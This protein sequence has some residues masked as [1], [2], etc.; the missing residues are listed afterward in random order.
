MPLSAEELAALGIKGHY[1]Y[2][3]YNQLIASDP[4]YLAAVGP[5][6]TISNQEKGATDLRKNTIRS[7]ITAFG[8]PSL[9]PGGAQGQFGSFLGT[10]PDLS[11]DVDA[12]ALAAAHGNQYSTLA[13][14]ALNDLR[15]N[16][17]I[18][19]S[20]AGRGTLYS[21][22]YAGGLRREQEAYGRQTYTDVMDLLTKMGTAGS[23]WLDTWNA[24]QGDRL[25]ALTSAGE[26]V[27]GLYPGTWVPDPEGGDGGAG[28]GGGGGGG[29][30]GPGPT[31]GGG[32]VTPGQVP[33]NPN[34]YGGVLAPPDDYSGVNTTPLI[35]PPQYNAPPANAYIPPVPTPNITGANPYHYG[36]VLNPDWF[37]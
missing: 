10:H 8:D 35:A 32:A 31:V 29:G 7:L 30:A 23:S 16:T 12:S 13:T 15:A 18:G 14:N 26:R 3:D 9:I 19:S 36:G 28:G 17:G 27:R 25:T 24:L 1:T 33:N 6:G 22:A 2:P 37:G 11:G 5:T 4:T 20:M 21:G 34:N